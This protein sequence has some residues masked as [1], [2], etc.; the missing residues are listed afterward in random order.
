VLPP[1][2]QDGTTAFKSGSLGI[3]G[4]RW[5]EVHAASVISGDVVFTD[6][7]CPICGKEFAKG[8]DIV[9]RVID[10]T[11]SSGGCLTRTVPAHY[12]CH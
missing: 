1:S 6:P 4:T 5:F 10:A 11:K 7:G 2:D 3:A 8:D 9:L 12:T